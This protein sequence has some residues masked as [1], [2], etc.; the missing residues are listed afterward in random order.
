[1]IDNRVAQHITVK[2]ISKYL[3]G[4]IFSED[5]QVQNSRLRAV[6]NKLEANCDTLHLPGTDLNEH[7]LY[8]DISEANE[9]RT[10]NISIHLEEIK[11]EEDA[12]EEAKSRH[13]SSFGLESNLFK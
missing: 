5:F 6:I 11:S 9:S 12:V 8:D 2:Q 10:N 1:M 4:S 13:S 3:T 7:L